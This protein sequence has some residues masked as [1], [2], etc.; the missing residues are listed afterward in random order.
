MS[1]LMRC[2][3][4][5]IAMTIKCSVSL[6]MVVPAETL[7]AVK[8]NPYSEYIY[9]FHWGQIFAL[10]MLEEVQC[11]QPANKWLA[12]LPRNGPVSWDQCWC[13]P[14][15]GYTL[16]SSWSQIC[17]HEGKSMMFCPCTVFTPTTSATF[18]INS[19]NK[20]S[21]ERSWQSASFCPPDILTLCAH[22]ES[23][24]YIPIPQTRASTPLTCCATVKSRREA[25]SCCN[26]PPSP[27][28]GKV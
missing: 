3:A 5:W 8:I 24:L 26:V 13:V 7:S 21:G 12:S 23:S 14:S 22:S 19:L 10:S 9:L 28:T 2:R 6:W 25:L 15:A 27:S 16:S 11:N 1:S 18:F 20:H 4:V 17:L